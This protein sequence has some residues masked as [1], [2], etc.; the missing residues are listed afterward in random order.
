MMNKNEIVD[1]WVT[2][3]KIVVGKSSLKASHLMTLPVMQAA[4][5]IQGC[6]FQPSCYKVLALVAG[7]VVQRTFS[8]RRVSLP[9]R[10]SDIDIGLII[11]SKDQ[12]FISW[13]SRNMLCDLVPDDA[14]ARRYNVLRG[15]Y[16]K[17]YAE[18]DELVKQVKEQP[19]IFL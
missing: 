12:L 10:L 1:E 11:H 5:W 2:V 3:K 15:L 19:Y 8:K 7:D 17:H 14:Y 9:V 18:I 13:L 6:I 16:G 4:E